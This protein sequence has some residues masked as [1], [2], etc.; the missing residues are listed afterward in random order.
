MT[1]TALKK[2]IHKKIDTV[3]DVVLLEAIQ[4]LLSKASEDKIL[5]S[6]LTS[7]ALKSEDDIKKGRLYSKEDVIKRLNL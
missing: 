3:N 2:Q 1:T 4:V 5:K 7:R 6:K